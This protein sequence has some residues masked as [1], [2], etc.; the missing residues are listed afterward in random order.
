[1]NAILVLAVAAFVLFALAQSAGASNVTTNGQPSSGSPAID[2]FANA[3]ARQEGFFVPG[4]ISSQANNPGDLVNGD[5][6][7][8]TLGSEN[9]T[10][11][12]SATDGWNALFIKLGNIANGQSHSYLPTMSFATMGLVWSGG[13]PNWGNNV[14]SILGA[15]VS[16]SIG[17]YLS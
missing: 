13:D 6:G 15:N 10:K 9:I 12:A 5:I 11:F 16:D 7:Y 4:S 2:A 14:A 8:G 17:A 1:M 3:I